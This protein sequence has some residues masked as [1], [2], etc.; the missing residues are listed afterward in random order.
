MEILSIR[1]FKRTSKI[2]VFLL[3]LFDIN[4]IP[5]EPATPEEVA[6]VKQQLS[7]G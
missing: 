5:A 1:I 7:Q 3:V 4:Y 2:R 6:A